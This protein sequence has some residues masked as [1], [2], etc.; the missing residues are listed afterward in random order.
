MTLPYTRALITGASRGLGAEFARQIAADGI[1]LVLVARTASDLDAL[2]S[3]VRDSHGVQVEILAADL[4]DD[5]AL[6]VVAKRLAADQAPVDLFVNNAGIGSSG[7]F[8]SNDLIAHL[9]LIDL[10]V[11]A[12]T[13]LAHAASGAMVNRGHGGIINVASLASFQ[14]APGASIY[15][16]GKAYLRSLSEAMFEELIGTGVKVLALCP[17]FTRTDIFEASGGSPDDVPAMLMAEPE[18][19]VA[20]ALRRLEQPGATT[21]PVWYNRAL[22]STMTHLP[23]PL[24]RFAMKQMNGI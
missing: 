23:R 8:A 24:V 22:A 17:G 9:R 5:G 1:D 14:S 21:V 20:T 15:S 3:E 16:A 11:R 13:R 19:V 7:K 18:Q 4:L 2:A 12:A 10:N 6:A